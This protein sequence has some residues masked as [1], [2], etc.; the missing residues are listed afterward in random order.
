MAINIVHI[1][2]LIGDTM[3]NN[4]LFLFLFIFFSAITT[5]C[6][7]KSEPMVTVSPGISLPIQEMNK[8]FIIEDLPV[9]ANSHKNG[10]YLELAVKNLSDKKIVFTKDYGLSIF[11]FQNQGWDSVQN[12][13]VYADNEN[14]LPVFDSFPPGLAV[15]AYPYIP[16]LIKPT[17]IRIV[18]IGHNGNSDTD[19]VGAYIDIP[20]FP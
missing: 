15:V 16:G 12:R 18:M 10:K 5:S 13:F 1:W 14:T 19:V 17:K 3:E 4:I 6:N 20:L 11:V 7:P 8:A 2:P 9:L